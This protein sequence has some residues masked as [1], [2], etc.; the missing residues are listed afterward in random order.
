MQKI[1]RPILACPEL[2][3]V[4]ARLIRE[5]L[6]GTFRPHGYNY[7]TQRLFKTLSCDLW[8]ADQL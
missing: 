1:N 2:L 7:H 8:S 5:A 6:R 4:A 3:A